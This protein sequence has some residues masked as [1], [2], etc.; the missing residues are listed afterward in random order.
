M[1][2]VNFVAPV[3]RTRLWSQEVNEADP[4]PEDKT[5]YIFNNGRRFNPEGQFAARRLDEPINE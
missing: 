3:I 5:N 1:N 4:Y 2:A